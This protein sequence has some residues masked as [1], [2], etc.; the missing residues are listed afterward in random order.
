MRKRGQ[1]ALRHGL[2]N[3]KEEEE[4]LARRDESAGGS[5]WER[6]AQYV[7]LSEKSTTGSGPPRFRELLLSL[8]N[9]ANAPSAQA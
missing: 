2:I 1:S 8:K 4:L 3:R 5:A 6:I 9:D 7:D